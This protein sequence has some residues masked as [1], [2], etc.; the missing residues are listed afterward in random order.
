[1]TIRKHS[2]IVIFGSTDIFA[3]FKT[4]WIWFVNFFSVYT[5]TYFAHTQ[6]TT[7]GFILQMP[8]VHACP[9]RFECVHRYTFK[10]EVTGQPQLVFETASS[11]A[12]SLPSMVNG[13]ASEP[14]WSALSTIWLLIFQALITIPIFGFIQFLV[15]LFKC[16]FWNL[17]SCPGLYK[18]SSKTE[19]SPKLSLLV[20]WEFYI[21]DYQRHWPVL[22]FLV[23][24]PTHEHE[25]SPVII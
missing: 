23:V 7:L 22:P 25:L 21:C 20:F 17:N 2:L 16:R 13:L 6:R 14:Q 10:C 5:G 19:L 18:A 3:Y 24:P 9:C 15:L 1:M 8:T 4:C 12:W 11:L